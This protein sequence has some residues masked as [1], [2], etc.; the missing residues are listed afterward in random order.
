MERSHHK[1]KITTLTT[2]T[3][4]MSTMSMMTRSCWCLSLLLLILAQASSAS[5]WV[6]CSSSSS[7]STSPTRLAAA[8]SRGASNSLKSSNKKF[9]QNKGA[10]PAF[11]KAA[12]PLTKSAQQSTSAKPVSTSTQSQPSPGG[13][14]DGD[15]DNGVEGIGIQDSGPV[16][17]ADE[18]MNR[19]NRRESSKRQ[20]QRKPLSNGF[21]TKPADAK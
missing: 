6:P 5:A 13:D 20:K 2:T 4:T 18:A 15:S 11:R 19:Q 17:S 9:A 12:H 3:T 10:Q 14:L 1:K 7:S 21:G 8:S 16:V